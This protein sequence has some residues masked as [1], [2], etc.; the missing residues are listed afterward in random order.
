[1]GGFT[2]FF[3]GAPQRSQVDFIPA[4]LYEFSGMLGDYLSALLGEGTATTYSENPFDINVPLSP[5]NQ[6]WGEMS[7]RYSTSP[8]P[9]IMGQAAG[10]LGNLMNPNMDLDA[11]N[12]LGGLFEGRDIN[13]LFN[14]PSY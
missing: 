7:Q 11:T 8:A 13:S 9:Y 14:P 10:T 2:E 4:P 6:M 1:M 3:Y 5:T 12:R